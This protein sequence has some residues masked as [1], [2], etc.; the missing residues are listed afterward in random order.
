MSEIKILETDKDGKMPEQSLSG[1]EF[2]IFLKE[3]H[4]WGLTVFI[5]ESPLKGGLEG[6]TKWEPMSITGVYLGHS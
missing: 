6:I 4:T 3:Y 2:Q 5:L 1:V